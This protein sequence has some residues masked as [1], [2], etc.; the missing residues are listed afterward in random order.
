MLEAQGHDHPDI[1]RYS[2]MAQRLSK[3]AQEQDEQ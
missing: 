1:E 2:Q 3:M